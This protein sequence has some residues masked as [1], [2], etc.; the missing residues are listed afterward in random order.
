MT[1]LAATLIAIVF[2]I[3]GAFTIKYEIFPYNL[4]RFLWGKFGAGS[5]AYHKHRKSLFESINQPADVVMIGD[6][7]TNGAEWSELFPDIR[8]ANRGINSDISD[9]V[10]ERMAGILNTEAK[11]A[12]LM[13]GIN[14]LSNYTSVNH[15]AQNIEAIVNQLMDYG[16]I[17]HIQSV[18][19]AG[20]KYGHLNPKV[21]KLNEKLKQLADRRGLNFIDLNPE[22]S[23]NQ[24][25]RPE[26]TLDDIHING[27]GYLAW[28]RKIGE[29]VR[30]S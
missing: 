9:L 13:I 29:V 26:F 4:I 25:L 17:V 14:D 3:W 15:I 12:F 1:Y 21:T 18:L 7:L 16:M 28:A 8:I 11:R 2:F 6:S 10:L 5:S 20:P 30:Q 24:T 27:P 23:R 22:L 19:Y